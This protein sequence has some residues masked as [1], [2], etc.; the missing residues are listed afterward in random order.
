MPDSIRGLLNGSGAKV[1]LVFK[2]SEGVINI[3]T[4]ERTSKF[5]FGVPG[6]PQPAVSAWLLA[7]HRAESDVRARCVC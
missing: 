7:G 5:P 3:A 4:A 2:V 6:R 1:R